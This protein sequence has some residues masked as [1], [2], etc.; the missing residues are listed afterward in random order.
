MSFDMLFQEKKNVFLRNSAN[1]HRVINVTLT[2]LM[3][4]GC[5][6]LHSYDA[7][8]IGT[9]KL[10]V[11]SSLKCLVTKISETKGLLVLFL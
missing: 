8:A 3:K 6:A 1:K 10:S 11:Q 7:A 9:S 2:K 4:P 5:N